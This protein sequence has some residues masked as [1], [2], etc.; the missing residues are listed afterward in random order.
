M[1]LEQ[2][3]TVRAWRQ[4]QEQDTGVSEKG[5]LGRERLRSMVL[6]AGA[7]DV[8]FVS[9][10]RPELDD[11]RAAIVEAFPR[12]RTLI[13][14][15]KR[16]NRE[17]IRS[18]T[19]S[20]ANLEFHHCGDSINAIGREVAQ[21]LEREGVGAVNVTMGF[22]M[23]MDR[24]PGRIWTVSHKPVAVAAGLGQMGIHRNV[25]HPKFGNFILLGTVLVEV[26]VADDDQP[27]DY[28]PCLECKLWV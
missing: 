11:Q 3:P 5:P 17:A 7:D 16:M 1:K 20:L 22:P 25:I 19:R 13:S 28:N 26:D 10:D 14:F 12:T 2:H 23:E 15:V 4:R 24:W 21:Q 8:G 6:A 18:T 27:I 9:L